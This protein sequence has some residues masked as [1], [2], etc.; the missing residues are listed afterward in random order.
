IMALVDRFYNAQTVSDAMAE[1]V[2][3]MRERVCTEG[4]DEV[5]VVIYVDRE[6]SVA[7]LVS[8]GQVGEVLE[9]VAFSAIYPCPPQAA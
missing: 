2:P 1:Y 9:S 8:T 5:F 3:R 4:R 7:D 6:R